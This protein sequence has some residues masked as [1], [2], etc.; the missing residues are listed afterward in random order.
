LHLLLDT[1]LSFVDPRRCFRRFRSG[2]PPR[3]AI[4]AIELF[5]S[6]ASAWEIARKSRLA[7]CHALLPSPP[8]WPAVVEAQ[9]YYRAPITFAQAQGGGSL[10]APHK[11]PSTTYRCAGYDRLVILVSNSSGFLTPMRQTVWSN[12]RGTV[13]AGGPPKKSPVDDNETIR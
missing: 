11:D 3:S 2:A 8:I 13:E 7:S 5:V 4:A 9:A 12:A 6:A 10:A 1:H